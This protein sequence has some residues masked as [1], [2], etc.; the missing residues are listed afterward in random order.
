MLKLSQ[1]ELKAIRLANLVEECPLSIC[2]S[3]LFLLFEMGSYQVALAGLEHCP[4]GSSSQR[5]LDPGQP[6]AG[7]KGACDRAQTDVVIVATSYQLYS[8]NQEQKCEV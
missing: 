5:F 1:A 8:E 4:P 6:S 7:I 2:W 3:L